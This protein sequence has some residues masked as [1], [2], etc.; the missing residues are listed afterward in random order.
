MWVWNV[1][2]GM[3]V[4]ICAYEHMCVRMHVYVRVS[5]YVYEL[6]PLLITAA[7]HIDTECFHIAM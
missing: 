2:M 5:V 1:G 3:Y 7:T 4:C 6:S